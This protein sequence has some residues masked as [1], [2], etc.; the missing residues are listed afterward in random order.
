M[1]DVHAPVRSMFYSIIT[2]EGLSCFEAGAAPDNT[3]TPHVIIADIQVA[4]NSD[5]TSFGSNVQILL[6]VVTYVL[7]NE[8]GG[9][10]LTDTMAGIILNKINSKTKLNIGNGLQ[11]V[12]T[13]VLQDIKQSSKSETHNIYR[14]LIRYQQLIKEV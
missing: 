7:K 2:G 11:V 10:L 8:A 13:K 1:Q 4:E 14:R 5:K 12:N 6:D 3:T 9:S